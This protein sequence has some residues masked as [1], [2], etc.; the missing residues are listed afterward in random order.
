MARAK[1]TLNLEKLHELERKMERV[2]DAK[3]KVGVLA[4]RGGNAQH[5]D[6]D[7]KATGIT[8]VE[9]AAIHEFGS[10]AANIPE[11]SFIRRT[12]I[13]KQD[14]LAGVIAK[15]ARGVVTEKIT[16]ERA[17]NVL[18]AW[19]AAEVKKTVTL[20]AHIPPPLQ[21]ETVARKKSNRPLVD[22]G[23]MVDSVQWE[24]VKS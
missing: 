15:L 11:R 23:R 10:P 18:G 5:V 19:G 2:G 9:L 16:L 7:G 13:E 6:A 24:I 3:V 8:M 17:L 20:G 14:A 4:S 21:P 12:F 1:Y 22:T